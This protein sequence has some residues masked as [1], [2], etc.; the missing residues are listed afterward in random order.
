MSRLA[1]ERENLRM[2]L[3]RQKAL[4]RKELFEDGLVT[5]L[6]REGKVKRYDSAIQRLRQ[7]YRS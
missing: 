4:S 5:E 1:A 3:K 6:I 7:S 2:S